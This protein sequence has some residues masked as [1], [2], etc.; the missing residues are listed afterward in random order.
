MLAWDFAAEIGVFRLHC[1][2]FCQINDNKE[3]EAM[4]ICTVLQKAWSWRRIEMAYSL[5]SASKPCFPPSLE[6]TCLGFVALFLMGKHSQELWTWIIDFLSNAW[7]FCPR[8][9]QIVGHSSELPWH[10]RCRCLSNRWYWCVSDV[11]GGVRGAERLGAPLVQLPDSSLALLHVFWIACPEFFRLWGVD[12]CPCSYK[13]CSLLM[14]L[15]F[16]IH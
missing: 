15:E 10:K 14:L 6:S 7:Q 8:Y 11:W 13:L 9:V 12:K 2:T 4:R 5:L 3:K 16:I 1:S